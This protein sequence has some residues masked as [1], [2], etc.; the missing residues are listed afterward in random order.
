MNHSELYR[1]VHMPDLFLQYI[2]C[3]N[4]LL[5]ERFLGTNCPSY[6]A[7]AEYSAPPSVDNRGWGR[8]GQI[9][10]RLTSLILLYFW[11]IGAK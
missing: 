5:Q 4:G 7:K 11:A 1:Y 10:N 9:L 8:P 6:T 2:G 3:R